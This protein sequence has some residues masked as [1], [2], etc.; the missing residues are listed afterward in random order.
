M[1]DKGK[2]FE[3][4]ARGK[5]K[6]NESD[7]FKG[8]TDNCRMV[9]DYGYQSGHDVWEDE[10]AEL[11]ARIKELE[12]VL[13]KIK[14]ATIGPEPILATLQVIKDKISKVMEKSNE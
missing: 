5:L 8:T 12:E 11:K 6:L 10:V 14:T 13:I 7:D 1:M 2:A 9:W 3:Q 4:L